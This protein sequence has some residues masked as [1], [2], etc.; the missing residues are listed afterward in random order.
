MGTR[1]L[2]LSRAVWPLGPALRPITGTGRK[3]R[4]V[5]E[6]CC[7]ETWKDC[8]AEWVWNAPGPVFRLV[9]LLLRVSCRVRRAARAFCAW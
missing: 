6:K 5:L 8:I 9:L 3:K 7:K 2:E 1:T 4:R